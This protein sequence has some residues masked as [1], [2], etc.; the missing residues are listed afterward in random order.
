VTTPAC[1][2]ATEARPCCFALRR[3]L[4][5]VEWIES[6]LTRKLLVIVVNADGGPLLEPDSRVLS[7]LKPLFDEATQFKGSRAK[8]VHILIPLV[9]KFALFHFI[10]GHTIP[11]H[12]DVIS[13]DDSPPR[14]LS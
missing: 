13:M 9:S 2:V 14:P 7:M 4:R 1:K 8:A 5:A 3:N 10:V 6:M 11:L 12:F